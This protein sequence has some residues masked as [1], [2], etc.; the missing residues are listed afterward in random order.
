VKSYRL[1]K[2]GS[3]DALEL[4]DDGES[5]LMPHEARVRMHAA[6]LNAR[7]LMIVQDSVPLG[8][9]KPGVVPLSDGAGEVVEVGAA[10]TDLAPGD[11][12]ATL[13][14]ARWID[15]PPIASYL[16]S[17]LGG[18]CDGT[19]RQ[20]AV[21]PAEGL[22]K[23]PKAL[24]FLEGAALGCASVTAWAA[25]V[26][27][28]PL[29]AGQTVLVQGT[30]GVSLFALQFAKA[31]G[32]RV[33]ALT[34][35]DAKAE[36]LKAI[37][38]DHVVNYLADPDWPGAVRALTDGAGVDRVIETGGPVTIERS[39]RAAAVGGHISIVGLTGG[40]EGSLSPLA[41]LGGG[42]TVEGIIVGSRRHFLDSL[43]SIEANA[44]RPVL[45][46]VLAFEDAK[47]AYQHMMDRKHIGKVIL[48][49][50]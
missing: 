34:S 46:Q 33:I 23:L 14:N 30:G 24:S 4:R 43:K 19:L 41:L 29:T 27:G 49:I 12:V 18:G 13:F 45:D 32:A 10:V 47:A 36:R 3:L 31:A 48:S 20:Q 2:L 38:A 21:F 11:R 42:L 26:G 39:V 22:V 17:A 1:G 7:D 50:T 8:G 9:T 37:G 5:P 16:G 40:V 35:S 6:S 44:I 28:R 15:G 25:L